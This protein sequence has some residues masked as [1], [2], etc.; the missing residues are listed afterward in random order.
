MGTS[1]FRLGATQTSTKQLVETINQTSHG[2]VEGDVIRPNAGVTGAFMKA[3]A[4]SALNAEA[5]G[6]VSEKA[7]H[8]FTVVYQGE[9]VSTGLTGFNGADVLFLSADIAGKLTN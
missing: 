9:C 1:A 7:T 8:S 4:D 5:I 2:F 3:Q 6:V